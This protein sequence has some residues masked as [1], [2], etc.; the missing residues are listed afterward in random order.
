MMIIIFKNN[1][2]KNNNNKTI[3][4]V[5]WPVAMKPIPLFDPTIRGYDNEDIDDSNNGKNIDTTQ[6]IHD[7][8]KLM[9]ELVTDGLVK[10]IG[11]SNFPVIL[12]HELLTKATIKPFINQC[13]CHIYLQQ[14][15]LIK[16][17]TARGIH[18]QAYSPL[19]AS[20]E[21]R[22]EGIDPIILN[23]PILQQLATKYNISVPTLCLVWLLQRNVSVVVKSTN[24]QHIH[25][26]LAIPLQLIKDNPNLINDKDLQTI[27]TLN[28]NYRYFRPQ[29][30]W[31]DMPVA[32]FH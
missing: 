18:F 25:D 31:I 12:L 26:N 32:V 30:W 11:V 20:K 19:G 10:Y 23:D 2:L 5:H 15:E 22:T 7:T 29:E 6:S 9:E 16:Y 3:N 28:R 21:Y 13:E 24:K 14:K 1:Y 17:C 27:A 8:W 4:I